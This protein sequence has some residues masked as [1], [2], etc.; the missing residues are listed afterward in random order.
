VHDADTYSWDQS[1]V[2]AAEFVLAFDV[3]SMKKSNTV[4]IVCGLCTVDSCGTM[5][6]T[7][8]RSIQELSAIRQDPDWPDWLDRTET[9][10][11]STG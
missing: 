8:M 9:V 4:A 6:V 5:A 7:S 3:R 2:D 1:C 10:P 11:F